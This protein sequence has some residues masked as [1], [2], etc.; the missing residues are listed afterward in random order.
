MYNQQDDTELTLHLL[1]EPTRRPF[2]DGLVWVKQSWQI[3][4]SKIGTWLLIGLVYGIC[5]LGVSLFGNLI[6]SIAKNDWI[7]FIPN[8]LLNFMFIALSAGIIIAT[9][10]YVEEDDIAVKYLFSGLQYKAKECFIYFVLLGIFMI[11]LGIILFLMLYESFNW[12][13][14]S[15]TINKLAVIFSLVY[16][17]GSMATWTALPLIVLHDISPLR[18]LKMSCIASLKN[19]LPALSYIFTMVVLMVGL[20]ITAAFV[21]GIITSIIGATSQSGLFSISAILLSI[22]TIF[23]IYLFTLLSLIVVYVSYRNIWTNLPLE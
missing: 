12:S 16:G 11:G 1:S 10:S 4:T 3:L 13:D 7:G 22:A 8:I 9:A 18:A 20:G 15:G 21:V 19:I 17:I 23:F 5:S 6:Q 2:G 14:L